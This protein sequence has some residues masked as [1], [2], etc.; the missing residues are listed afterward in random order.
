[1]ENLRA[2]LK[3]YR[4]IE[5]RELDRRYELWDEAEEADDYGDYDDFHH[6]SMQCLEEAGAYLA[7]AIEEFL[8]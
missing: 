5:Q 4:E 1:M 7:E 8:K 2:V 6:A 3:R